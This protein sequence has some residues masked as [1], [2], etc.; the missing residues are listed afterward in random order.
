MNNFSRINDNNIKRNW[1]KYLRNNINIWTIY[2]E[3]IHFLILVLKNKYL[4]KLSK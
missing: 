2:I 1:K 4:L 3:I